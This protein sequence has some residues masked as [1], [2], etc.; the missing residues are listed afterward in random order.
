M[1]LELNDVCIRYSKSKPILENIDLSIH[2]GEFIGIAGRS[3]SGKTT[4]LET[5]GGFHKPICGTIFFENKEIFNKSFD[6]ISFRKKL[7]IVFQFP[8]NQF[9]EKSVFDEVAF[10]LKMMKLSDDEINLKTYK[11]IENVGLSEDSIWEKSPFI[12]SGGEKR[13]VAVACALAQEP[14]ILLLD[15]PFSGLDRDG[16]NYLK[17]ILLELNENGTTIL[18]VSHD[19]ETLCELCSRIL[20]I[21]HGKIIKDGKPIEIFSSMEDCKQW[22]IDIPDTVK[23]ANIIGLDL[24]DDPSY[25]SFLE[26]LT[27]KL[28]GVIS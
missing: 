19:I 4:L 28:Q 2:K 16:S 6:K 5:I 12:L 22:G 13:R 25:A 18:M 20:V 27:K 24:S 26:K 14:E 11:A 17:E 21:S 10:G 3:G 23:I 15:E 9:F 1:Q 8:E 7:Q